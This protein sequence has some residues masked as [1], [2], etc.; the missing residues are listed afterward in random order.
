VF[1]R[2]YYNVFIFQAI[3]S[4]QQ[5]QRYINCKLGGPARGADLVFVEQ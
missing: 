2:V 1:N 4:S 3:D 5:F